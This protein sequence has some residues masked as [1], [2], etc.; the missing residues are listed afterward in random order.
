MKVLVSLTYYLPNI[1]GVTIYAQRL[2][3]ELAK[4]GHAVT[5]LTSQHKKDLSSQEILNGVKIE[6]LKVGLKIGKGVFMPTLPIKALMLLRE[7][8]V[9]NCHLPQFESFILAVIA[10]LLG[11]KVVLTHHT[12][13]SHWPGVF[14]RISETAVFVGQLISGFLA[15]KIIPY[16]KD[17]ADHSY[18]LKFFKK[19]PVY[20]YPP[21][22]APK[23]D[24]LLQKELKQK[25]GSTKFKIGFAGRI[26]RQKGIPYLLDAIPWLRKKLSEDFKIV[27]AGPE[28]EVIGERFYQEIEA[29]IKKYQKNLIF[30]GSIPPEKIG[31]FYKAIDCL[32]L[33]SDDRLESFGL[34]Q[35]EAMFCGVPVVAT[36]LP[37]VRVPIKLAGMGE[38]VP[39]RNSKK[40]AEAIVKVLQN[41][42]K[43]MRPKK[44]IEKI[45]NFEETINQYERLFKN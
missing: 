28:R 21:I 43:Y 35:V 9:L 37:G 23:I 1:S 41:R 4:R 33:P 31:S 8:D 39:V 7:A 10:K 27:F 45:F 11:K 24:A 32:V 12:D 15:D 19:K 17:Y 14:N 29:K 34:V 26:A 20:C 18:Y 44:E 40:L 5:V 38:I 42:K 13:L 2:A 6:R 36:D 25:I 22:K 16:T 3:E 30:L